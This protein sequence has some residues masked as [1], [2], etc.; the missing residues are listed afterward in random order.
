MSLTQS[1]QRGV[2]TS[3][4]AGSVTPCHT[5]TSSRA[6]PRKPSINGKRVAVSAGL[7]GVEV[8][9]FNMVWIILGE[10]D[11]RVQVALLWQ[12]VASKQGAGSHRIAWLVVGEHTGSM[13]PHHH[14]PAISEPGT[15][16]VLGSSLTGPWPEDTQVIYCAMGCFWGAEQ[17][18]WRQ[19]G[20]VSTAVG[21]MGGDNQ[22][23]PEP[24]YEQVCSGET[25]HAETVQVA[26]DPERI[27]AD[28]LLRVFWENHDPTTAD[29]QGNDVGSQYRS[30]I[31]WT[32]PPQQE[33]ALQTKDSFGQAL[34]HKD[35]GPIVTQIS[36]AEQA[37][38]FWLAEDYHQQYLEKNP[39][40]YCPVHATGVHCR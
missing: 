30:A 31:F 1:S 22:R 6:L 19:P 14:Q 25:G 9:S 39:D 15:H 10:F 8:A 29:R 36:A 32:T 21:Y 17:L 12:Q 4:R 27:G 13:F 33:L 26:Y 34:A 38:P 16:L 11:G 20:V 35:Y 5:T 3:N 40:G 18:F 7:L 28:E 2:G 23:W 37:G 24:S